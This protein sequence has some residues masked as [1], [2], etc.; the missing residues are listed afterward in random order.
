M[1]INL[2]FWGGQKLKDNEQERGCTED[3]HAAGS[4]CEIVGNGNDEELIQIL[5]KFFEIRKFNRIPNIDKIKQNTRKWD[6]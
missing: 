3:G 6:K 4:R 5:N 2:I 1:K